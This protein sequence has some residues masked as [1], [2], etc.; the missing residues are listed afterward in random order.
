MF[1]VTPATQ[2]GSSISEGVEY[3][4]EDLFDGIT[5]SNKYKDTEQFDFEKCIFIVLVNRK[6]PKL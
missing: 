1:P 2:V 5:I 6:C 3:D 4:S